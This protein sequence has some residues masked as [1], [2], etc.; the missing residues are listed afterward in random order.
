MDGFTYASNSY[1]ASSSQLPVLFSNEQLRDITGNP[2]AKWAFP[3]IGRDEA[4]GNRVLFD[5]IDNLVNSFINEDAVINGRKREHYYDRYLGKTMSLDYIKGIDGLFIARQNITWLHKFYKWIGESRLRMENAR[6]KPIFLDRN[7]KPC[8]AFDK[9]NHPILFLPIKNSG[10]YRIILPALLKNKTTQEFIDKIGVQEPSLRDQIYNIILPQYRLRTPDDTDEHFSLLFKYYCE[11]PNGELKDYI[12]MINRCSFLNYD[13]DKQKKAGHDMAAS[14][15]FPTVEIKKF[16]KTKPTA[17][18]VSLKEYERLV[19]NK[20]KE[21][22]HQFLKDLGVNS[23]IAIVTKTVDFESR[24]DLPNDYSTRLAEWTERVIDGCQEIVSAIV[25]KKDREKSLLLWNT[26]VRLVTKYCLGENDSDFDELI[27]GEYHYHYRVAMTKTFESSDTQMLRTSKW[28]VNKKGEFVSPK[29]VNK[30][31]LE[32]IYETKSAGAMHLLKYLGILDFS[33]EDTKNL[34]DTQRRKIQFVNQ[35]LSKLGNGLDEDDLENLTDDFAAFLQAKKKKSSKDNSQLPETIREESQVQHDTESKTETLESS[36]EVSNYSSEIEGQDTTQ[37][38]VREVLK[39]TKEIKT[40]YLSENKGWQEIPDSFDDISEQEDSDEYLPA[41]IDYSKLIERAEQKNAQ[42]L[43]KIIQ[44]QKLQE[45]IC[46]QKKYSY[47]WFT[48]LLEMECLSGYSNQYNNREV[49]ISFSKITREENTKRTL[50]LHYP[51]R[52]IPQFM[53]D[54]TDV[55]LVLH[56]EDAKRQLMIEVINIQSYTLRIKLKSSENIEGI[57]FNKVINATI[58]AKNPIFL[59]KE[60]RDKILA[61]NYQES[62]NMQ[63]NLCKN[64]EFVFGPPGT[65]KTT[66]LAKNVIPPMMRKQ[67]NSKVLVLTPTNKAADVLV[68]RIMEADKYGEY[69]NWLIR[70]GT[71]GDEFIEESEVY[72]DK[73]FDFRKMPKSVTVTTIAR[74]PYDYFMPDKERIYLD[75]IKWDYIIIDEASMIPLVNLIYPLYKKTPE[76][77]IIAGDPFQ[78]GPI[79]S[80]NQWKND[81]IYTMVQLDS[82]EKPRTVPHTYKVTSLTTQYRSIPDVGEVFSRFAYGGI[83]THYRKNESQKPLNTGGKLAVNT[84]NILKYP[85]SKYESIYKAKKLQNSPYHVYSALFTYEYICRFSRIIAEN[86][87]SVKYRV[88]IIAPYRAEAD[89]LDKLISSETMPNTV[90]VQVGTIHRFQGDEC[91]IIFA[92]LNS[93]PTISSSD[94]MFLNK[95]NIIN[96]AISRAKDYLFV[97]MPDDNTENIENLHLVK[98]VEE[99]MKK[100]SGKCNESLTPVIEKELFGDEKYVENN[101]FSTSH[102]NVN[103][104]GIPEKKYEVRLNEDAVDIQIHRN[105]PEINIHKK[106]I[107]ETPEVHRKPAEIPPIQ[108]EGRAQTTHKQDSRLGLVPEELRQKAHLI[109]VI[110]AFSG[111][112]Y[113]VPYS[114]RLKNYTKKSV[115]GM[116][117]LI[118]DKGK[119]KRIPVSMVQEDHIMYIEQL[120]YLSYQGKFDNV[121]LR[122]SFFD[123]K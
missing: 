10:E 95:L 120:T 63:S 112:Y 118:M 66:Y 55:P 47:G 91:D 52:Y 12:E 9:T 108:Q 26:L 110:G 87:P 44:S 16:L 57:N 40:D 50:V 109:N 18:Y 33:Q 46:S 81:N 28:L 22:L 70:F 19:G 114:G 78:I 106:R 32:D 43:S 75:E 8:A 96:V 103:V 41:A 27:I 100:S 29:E 35:L 20:N 51:N 115:R 74:F 93:P 72:K 58:D 15:Y 39:K 5:Y 11:C 92:V 105:R 83:L 90:D 107:E 34:T 77:F 61:L 60:L 14:L 53:E 49:S 68:K 111:E 88:G 6:T 79:T 64:I 122:Q 116:S 84:L 1:W 123:Q 101:T 54:L 119:E 98:K 17:H 97:I 4:R 104:Y 56:F 31:A 80:V 42:D 25:K 24:D 102:H 59:L 21:K 89:I 69:N 85:V 37:T 7:K 82:F 67:G 48:A 62:F 45:K 65:G 30:Q 23:E 76:K 73:T 86:N 3:T 121:E 99:I 13:T 117:I 94:E 36:Y 38:V 71:T 113:L 2:K